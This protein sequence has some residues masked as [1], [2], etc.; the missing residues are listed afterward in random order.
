MKKNLILDFGGVILDIDYHKTKDAFI[1]LGFTQFNEMY[2]QYH[3]DE[4]FTKLEKGEVSSQA[5]YDII[6]SSAPAGVSREQIE[7]AW[8][9]MLLQ[10]RKSTL[11]YLPTLAEKYNLYLL[12]NTNAIHHRAFMTMYEEGKPSQPFDDCFVKAYYSHKIGY[13]K[14]NADIYEFVASDAGI[15]PNET[16]F[17]DDSY[18]NIEAAAAVGYKTHLL[19]AEEQVENLDLE[20]YFTSS[21]SM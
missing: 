1:D 20:S 10:Y 8:N 16:L 15:N 14:P 19:L 5:F 21:K 4:L 18:N 12:S 11:T 13:R 2:N 9:A 3:S 7:Q 17:I 6:L